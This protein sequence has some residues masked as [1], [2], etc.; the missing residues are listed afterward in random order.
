V[1]YQGWACRTTKDQTLC[2]HCGADMGGWMTT[3]CLLKDYEPEDHHL[4]MVFVDQKPDFAGWEAVPVSPLVFPVGT[5]VWC[6]DTRHDADRHQYA[7][8]FTVDDAVAWLH[9][10]EPTLDAYIAIAVQVDAAMTRHFQE[11]ERLRVTCQELSG[12]I[13]HLRKRANRGY[14]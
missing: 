2:I 11:T 10:V 1:S 3:S 7:R 6:L 12:M 14:E 9:E 4:A 13:G 5:R 8:T